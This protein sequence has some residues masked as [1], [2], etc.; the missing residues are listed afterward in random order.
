MKTTLLQ[1]KQLLQQVLAKL[2]PYFSYAS[3]LQALLDSEYITNEV[4]TSMSQFLAQHIRAYKEEML[5]KQKQVLASKVQQQQEHDVADAE[6][7][8]DSFITWP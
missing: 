5:A 7:M 1:R 6:Q 8:L 2:E 3:S 4:C